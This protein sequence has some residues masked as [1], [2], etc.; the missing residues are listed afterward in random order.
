MM[1]GVHYMSQYKYIV[2]KL[3]NNKFHVGRLGVNES[4][5]EVFCTCTDKDKAKQIMEALARREEGRT[6]HQ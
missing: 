2:A 3:S 4:N 1:N 6:W 5:Y